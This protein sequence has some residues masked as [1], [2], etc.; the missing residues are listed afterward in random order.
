MVSPEHGRARIR[1]VDPV[2]GTEEDKYHRTRTGEQGDAPIGDRLQSQDLPAGRQEYLKF[3]KKRSKI[4]AGRLAFTVFVKSMVHYLK[5]L[6]Q[7]I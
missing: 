2:H 1:N 6:S 4:G 7:C 3:E 5:S